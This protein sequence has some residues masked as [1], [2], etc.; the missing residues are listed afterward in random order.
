MF[1]LHVLTLHLSMLHNSYYHWCLLLILIIPTSLVWCISGSGE[2]L[3]TSGLFVRQ[4]RVLPEL[5]PTRG[6]RTRLQ[7]VSNRQKNTYQI[8]FIPRVYC[9]PILLCSAH[10]EMSLHW[11]T[12]L[13]IVTC[14]LLSLCKIF[15]RIPNIYLNNKNLK[16]LNKTR[17]NIWT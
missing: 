17:K 3:N 11:L 2:C 14:A 1:A 10:T 16:I 5:S 15:R 6:R 7:C 8:Q 9:P 4:W 12:I 13:F